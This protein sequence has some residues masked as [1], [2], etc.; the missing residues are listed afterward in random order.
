MVHYVVRLFVSASVY[1]ILGLCCY[2][3]ALMVLN[4]L[5]LTYMY[6][7]R[8]CMVILSLLN[9]VVLVSRLSMFS[10][11]F[12]CTILFR[13][14][15]LF[16]LLLLV[17]LLFYMMLSLLGE[18]VYTSAVLNR[19]SMHFPNSCLHMFLIFLFSWRHATNPRYLFP[20]IWYVISLCC[21]I[22]NRSRVCAGDRGDKYI[23]PP[24]DTI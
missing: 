22:S 21:Y 13:L 4:L 18:N 20:I 11:Y 2:G 17:D 23:W 10:T 14:S 19:S 6:T 8:L 12:S 24:V 15:C 1:N 16:C 5:Y 3:I 7:L 9:V